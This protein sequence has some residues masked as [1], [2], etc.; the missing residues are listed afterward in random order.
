MEEENWMSDTTIGVNVMLW[1]KT[2]EQMTDYY[3]GRLFNREGHV[4]DLHEFSD[5]CICPCFFTSIE[6]IVD[7]IQ[8]GIERFRNPNFDSESVGEYDSIQFTSEMRRSHIQAN[9]YIES[10]GAYMQHSLNPTAMEQ[11]V[12][13][14]DKKMRPLLYQ[15]PVGKPVQ[16]EST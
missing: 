5:K 13:R 7:A 3:S 1:R 15:Q 6:D 12:L 8:E 10:Q 16:S 2:T 14:V 11:L 4:A 9:A